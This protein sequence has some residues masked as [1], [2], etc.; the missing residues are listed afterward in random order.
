ME[1]VLMPKFFFFAIWFQLTVIIMYRGTVYGD[2]AIDMAKQLKVWEF[3]R[4]DTQLATKLL[5]PCIGSWVIM[6]FFLGVRIP[7]N[8]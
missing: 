3:Y 2:I 4:E 8:F 1:L 5:L 7:I 6:W